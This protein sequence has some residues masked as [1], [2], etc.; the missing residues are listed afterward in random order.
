MGYEQTG[1]DKTGLDMTG[2]GDPNGVEPWRRNDGRAPGS[3]PLKVVF[4]PRGEGR[5]PDAEALSQAGI[6]LQQQPADLSTLAENSP[7]L[8]EADAVVVEVQPGDAANLDAFDRLIH[9]AAGG[10]AV[11]AAV[12][13]LTVADTRTLLR[14]GA[15][16]VLPIPF[17]AEELRQAVEPAR[18]PVR[19]ALRHATPQRRQGKVVAFMGALGGVG[20]TSIAVQTGAVLAASSRVGLVDL[21]VQFGSA[22][23]FLNLHPSLHIG[24]LIED[25]ERLDAEL[26]QSV[27]V[28]H[29]SSLEVLPSPPDV[30]PLDIVTQ[31]FVDQ[32]LRT[33]VQIYDVVLVDLPQAW[34]EWS[35]RVLQRADAVVLVTNLSVSGVYQARRQ[36]EV[37]EANGLTSKLK[38]VANRVPTNL[39]GRKADTKETEAVLRRKVDYTVGNDYP[40]M[41]GAND[42]G[43]VLKASR[44]LKDVQLLAA[45]LAES[46]AAEASPQ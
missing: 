25:A 12:E 13:G 5:A 33:A 34:T 3:G 22:A 24:N 7:L 23:L 17:S 19:P 28:R 46:L 39:L 10:V 42:E 37:L 30:M 36:L 6:T 32:L 43:V 21:D 4:V 40:G 15:L 8:N 20:T 26:L 44:L 38:I 1:L 31:E 14:A 18:R 2:Q 16:D 29:A 27:A 41:S 45:S 35:V 9:L 11:V